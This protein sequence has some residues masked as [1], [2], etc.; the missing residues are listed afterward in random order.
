MTARLLRRIRRLETSAGLLGQSGPRDAVV[1]AALARVSTADLFLLMEAAESQRPYPEWNG[2]QVSAGESLRSAMEAEC[3]RAGFKSM[4]EFDRL[5][6][7]TI[8]AP[9]PRTAG[10]AYLR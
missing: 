9:N 1:S 10:R 6:P 8:T 4:A 5:H 3:T 7:L 2:D